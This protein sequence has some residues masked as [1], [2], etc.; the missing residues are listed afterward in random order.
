MN[1][2]KQIRVTHPF[3]PLYGQA[4]DFVTHDRGWGENRVFFYNPQG[5]LTS[6]PARWTSIVLAD[7]F[8]TQ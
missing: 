6:I 7:P 4:F 3:H 2:L 1:D 5:K 8:L